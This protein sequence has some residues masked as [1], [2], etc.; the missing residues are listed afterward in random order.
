MRVLA[1]VVGPLL[2]VGLQVVLLLE[3]EV[4]ALIGNL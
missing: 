2:S 3:P 1:V 4:L